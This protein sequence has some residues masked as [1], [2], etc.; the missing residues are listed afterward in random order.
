MLVSTVFQL[1]CFGYL[2]HAEPTTAFW[3]VAQAHPSPSVCPTVTFGTW[4]A[5]FTDYGCCLTFLPENSRTPSAATMTSVST[6]YG[7]CPIG[8]V[9]TGDVTVSDWVTDSEGE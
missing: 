6:G 5:S 4:I 3:T 8:Y 7:C 1:F 2:A 9:C